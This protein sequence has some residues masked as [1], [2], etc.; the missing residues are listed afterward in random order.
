MT[1]DPRTVTEDASLPEI[2][3]L[4]E[5][6]Q[7]KRVPVIRGQQV[8]GVVSRANLLHPL[9]D[10]V[11]LEAK[12]TAQGDKTIRTQLLAELAKYTWAPNWLIDATVRNG[13]VELWGVIL[14]DR[15]RAALIVAAENVPGVK[16]AR[17]HLAWV[18]TITGVVIEPPVE[19]AT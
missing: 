11:V 10:D 15:E 14:D 13:V 3:R 17:D 1:P 12:P 6:R 7:I 16:A 8:V 5:K 19:T 18:D 2:V 4:M 9:A